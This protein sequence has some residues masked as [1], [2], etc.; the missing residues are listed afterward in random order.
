MADLTVSSAV[1]TFMAAAN[2]AAMLS[3]LNI[4]LG[5]A[6]ATSGAFSLTLTTTGATNVTLPTSGTLAI[7]GAN[8]FTGTQTIATTGANSAPPLYLTGALNVAG[9]GTTTFPHIFHQPTGAT[10]CTTWSSGANAGTVF[11]ANENTSFAGDYFAAAQGGTRKVRITSNGDGHFQNSIQLGSMSTNGLCAMSISGTGI[12]FV[13]NG[14]FG[15]K[16]SASDLR[17]PSSW[18]VAWTDGTGYGGTADLFQNRR[19]AAHL[20]L[21]ASSATPIA[22]TFGGA[23]GLGSNITGGV[24]NIGTR[25]TGTGVGGVINFQSHAAGASSSTLGT[26]ATV[27]QITSATLVTLSSGVALRLGNA[28][29]TGLTAGVDAALTNATIVLQDST[30]QAYR[31]PCI[32]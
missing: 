16:F 9:N 28:A 17:F 8:T 10:A 24:L 21:G 19:A 32:I 27:M 26:L 4:T 23:E 25:G 2:Q 7:L 15:C 20:G 1:D 30:G 22:Q 31:I 13:T 3:A 11:G 18:S 6:F 29:T 5:G 14:S 12:L